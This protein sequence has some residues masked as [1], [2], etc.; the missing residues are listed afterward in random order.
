MDRLVERSALCNKLQRNP[1]RIVMNRIQ[2]D[3]RIASLAGGRPVGALFPLKGVALELADGATVRASLGDDDLNYGAANATGTK[4]LRRRRPAREPNG[5]A[6]ALTSVSPHRRGMPRGWSEDVS[7]RR[8]G[9]ARGWSEDASPRRRGG[10]TALDA[11]WTFRGDG[12]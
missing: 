8:R 6:A 4:K 2:A 3:P 10:A 1:I 11:T 12:S 5:D 7:R 9:A